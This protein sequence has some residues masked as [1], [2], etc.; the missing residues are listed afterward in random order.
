MERER[1]KSDKKVTKKKV[2]KEWR[3]KEV[4][5]GK[6]NVWFEGKGERTFFSYFFLSLSLYRSWSNF[7]Q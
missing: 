5:G 7:M 2:G 6:A 1:E 3:E 4:V